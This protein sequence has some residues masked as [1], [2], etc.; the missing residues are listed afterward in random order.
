VISWFENLL[1]QIQLVPLHH[2]HCGDV[3]AQAKYSL[4]SSRWTMPRAWYT[5]YINI[6]GGGGTVQLIFV[7]W[8]AL[9]VR[10]YKLNSVYPYE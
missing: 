3:A 9:E 10:L 7:D 1:F 6:P 8:V 5:Q 2:D 4:Q